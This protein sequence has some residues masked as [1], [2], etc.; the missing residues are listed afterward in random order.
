M[1]ANTTSFSIDGLQADSAYRVSEMIA[2][3]RAAW[4]ERDVTRPRWTEA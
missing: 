1:P 4:E 3:R 2:A